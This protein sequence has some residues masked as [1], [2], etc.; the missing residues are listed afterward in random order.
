MEKINLHSL[1]LLVG[2][3]G[4]GKSTLAAKHFEPHEVVSSDG[5]RAELLG[6]FRIQTNQFEVWEEVHRRVRQRLAFGQRVVVD[7]TNIKF[8]DRK[9]F[10]DMAKHYNVELVYLVINRTVDAKLKTAGWRLEVNGLIERHEEVYNNN[11]KDIM[12]GDGIARVIKL[13]DNTELEVVNLPLETGNTLVASTIGRVN[14]IVTKPV[15]VVGDV[16]GNVNE[17]AI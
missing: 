6:D 16:H 8:G 13:F 5:I 4:S 11:L 1:V 15:T 3:S 7:A 9:A 2:P 12:R 17:L 10:V 14:K